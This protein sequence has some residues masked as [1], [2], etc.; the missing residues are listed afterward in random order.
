MTPLTWLEIAA[1][2]TLLTSVF[3]A[4]RNRPSSWVLG[5]VACALFGVF[6]FQIKLY[7]DVTLQV[8]FIV[9]NVIGWL[10][11]QR[12]GEGHGV[13]P[14]TPVRPLWHLVL[15]FPLAAGAAWGYSEVLRQFTDAHYPLFDSVI[16][17]FSIVAQFLLMK[18]KIETWVFW[19]IVN[20]V[21]VPLYAVKG[22]YVTAAV[23]AL[24]WLN[25]F[26]GYWTWRAEM[27]E[28]D[29]DATPA[30]SDVKM[31][32]FVGA[33]ST[34]KSTLAERL[35]AELGTVFVEEYGRTLWVERGGKLDFEDY[36]H[37]AETH[38]AM[39]EAARGKASRFVFVD[40]TP[41]TTLFYSQEHMGRV[42]PKLRELSSRAYDVTF[43]CHPDFPLVQ[44]GWRGDDAFREAQHEWYVREL[45]E[46]GVPYVSLTGTL[47]EKVAKVKAIL[48]IVNA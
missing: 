29:A 6:F 5:V 36:L 2:V 1:N 34:G 21:A 14:I 37:I 12:G 23:Y 22:A 27:R 45:R 20:T 8:F 42:D 13:L 25:A 33:E 24:F 48:G 19:L 38:I 7:A 46:R 9:T 17:T 16:L 26:Y 3:L 44:D 18:R 11:W 39:E 41:L 43:L 4:A 30:P 15:Y 28:D 31:V 47:E 40:T 32:C 35:A 10:N